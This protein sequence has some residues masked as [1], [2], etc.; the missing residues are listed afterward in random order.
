M[1]F[2]LHAFK[3]FKFVLLIMCMT[4][5]CHCMFSV[6]ETNQNKS[7]RSQNE[8]KRPKKDAKITKYKETGT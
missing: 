5:L 8:E 2:V 3:S 4:T 6:E 1:H 7:K